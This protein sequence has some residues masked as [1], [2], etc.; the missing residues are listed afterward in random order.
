[1]V[2]HPP[3]LLLLLLVLLLVL[4]GA[5]G[6]ASATI[7]SRRVVP[8]LLRIAAHRVP[9]TLQHLH[10]L[11]AAYRPVLAVGVAQLQ[12]ALVRKLVEGERALRFALLVV[13]DIDLEAEDAANGAHPGGHAG[14]RRSEIRSN[15]RCFVR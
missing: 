9:L 13:G 7:G 10:E 6:T 12:A 14:N 5:A 2:G 3:P 11:A 8:A 15:S 4:R 1:M